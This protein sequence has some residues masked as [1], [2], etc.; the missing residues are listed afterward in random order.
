MEG[1]D[2]R[3]FPDPAGAGAMGAAKAAAQGEQP[4]DGRGSAAGTGKP[5]KS[6]EPSALDAERYIR[7]AGLGKDAAGVLRALHGGKIM[8]GEKWDREAEALLEKT[9]W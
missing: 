7:R 2:P 9:T 3:G 5:G 8:S 1:A 4:R 6:A